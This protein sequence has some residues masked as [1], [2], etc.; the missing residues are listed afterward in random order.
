MNIQ[1]SPSQ[2]NQPILIVQIIFNFETDL[3]FADLQQKQ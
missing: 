2:K 1:I 3:K